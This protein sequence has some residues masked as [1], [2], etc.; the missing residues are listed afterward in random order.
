MNYELT[1][2]SMPL[3]G[4]LS[5]LVAIF[6]LA[7]VAVCSPMDRRAYDI[8][9]LVSRF[10]TQEGGRELSDDE[11]TAVVTGGTSDNLQVRMA[12]AYALAFT[13]K[14]A[15]TNALA[16]LAK[17]TSPAVAGVAEYALFLKQ[18]VH[19]E[20]RELFAVLSY[21]LGASMLPWSRTLLV[22][23]LGDEFKSSAIPMFLV[24]L[25]TQADE[26]TRAEIY[27][28]IANHGNRVQLA[29]ISTLLKDEK[30]DPAR[31]F[32]AGQGD[33]LNRVSSNPRKR[34]FLP[35]FLEMLIELRLEELAEHENH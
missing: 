34:A 30:Q 23:K 4:R 24:A 20:K 8:L 25:E 31:A 9:E 11:L 29:A 35:G 21:R 22:S 19:L 27:F 10:S 32:R 2:M 33:F 3:L 28:Q 15:G 12:A 6:A 7:T 16:K 17:D 26:L 14:D 5:M 18:S 1:D 13:E